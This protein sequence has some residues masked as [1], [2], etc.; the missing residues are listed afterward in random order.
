[1][2]KITYDIGAVA[3]GENEGST[4]AERAGTRS[5][6]ICFSEGYIGIA[7]TIVNA[8]QRFA[9]LG[10]HV[11]ILTFEA[12]GKFPPAPA[13]QGCIKIIQIRRFRQWSR[14]ACIIDLLRM[15]FISMFS[16]Y[17]FVIGIDMIGVLGGY[18]ALIRSRQRRP[19]FI[20][21]SLEIP[22]RP[23]PGGRI[24]RVLQWFEMKLLKRADLIVVQDR[25][26]ARLLCEQN[27]LSN[28]ATAFVPN[29]A[30]GRA[31]IGQS[32]YLHDRLGIAREVRIVLH[33]GMIGDEVMSF[34]LAAA[35]RNWPDSHVLVL[36]ERENRNPDDPY[37]VAIREAAGGRVKL[38]LT[39]VPLNELDKVVSSAK[40]GIVLYSPDHGENFSTVGF[41]SGKLSYYLRNGV[42]VIVNSVPALEEIV[43]SNR[44]G[45]V[46]KDMSEIGNAIV[47]IE[48]K[49]S[50]YSAK[51]LECFD[52]HFDFRTRFDAAFA[53]W[54]QT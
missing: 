36:H 7:P 14:F 21:W 19:K 15:A 39:P 42:P 26:R 24:M 9:E 49:Y 12:E 8:A 27:K 38:S 3:D 28:V 2:P 11:D 46:V 43:N 53:H 23:H 32:S 35:A 51:A 33:A 1:M 37:L 6:L 31:N 10:V 50:L 29:S 52:K 47:E 13:F 25:Y 41:A 30:M 22:P 20:C 34:K 4:A 16:S 5:C 18:A 48:S 17:D 40:I 54:L 45:I 44:C